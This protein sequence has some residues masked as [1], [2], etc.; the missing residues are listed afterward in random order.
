MASQV[1]VT[2]NEILSFV[3][4]SDEVNRRNCQQTRYIFY[5]EKTKLKEKQQHNTRKQTK[6]FD[7]ALHKTASKKDE[8]NMNQHL[9]VVKDFMITFLLN[10]F[11]LRLAND[12]HRRM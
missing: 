12:N 5:S 1:T 6:T 9:N 2:T 4:L 11:A 10:I 8:E 3:L 7:A